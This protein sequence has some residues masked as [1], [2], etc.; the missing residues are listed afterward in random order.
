MGF[1]VPKQKDFV[2]P[3][4]EDDLWNMGILGE[5]DPDTLRCTIFHFIGSRFGLC[6]GKEH[7]S[8]ARFPQSQITI[9]QKPDGSDYLVYHEF[10][11]GTN[12]GGICSHSKKG[13]VSYAFYSGFR[14]RCFVAIYKEYIYKCPEPTIF[15]NAF[16]EN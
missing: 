10:V 1:G 3:E 2:T 15:W 13:K 8:L 9:E 11:S 7:W 16:S 12:Q 5:T 4:L 6:G 14:P